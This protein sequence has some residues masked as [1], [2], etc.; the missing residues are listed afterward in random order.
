M[1]GFKTLHTVVGQF[2][3]IFLFMTSAGMKFIAFWDVA[4]C[5]TVEVYRRFRGAYC[6]AFPAIV[7]IMEVVRIS[8]TSLN[9][10]RTTRRNIP[11]DMANYASFLFSRSLAFAGTYNIQSRQRSGDSLQSKS[12]T[13][14][15]QW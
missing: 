15:C 4:P 9:F 6:L 3:Y 12:S 2:N 10:Y 11:E 5:C 1:T 8:E 7:L 14:G 13:A